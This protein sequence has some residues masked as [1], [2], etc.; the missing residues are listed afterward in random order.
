MISWGSLDWQLSLLSE[1]AWRTPEEQQ[2]DWHLVPVCVHAHVRCTVSGCISVDFKKRIGKVFCKC[3]VSTLFTLYH[4]ERLLNGQCLEH[5]SA[6]INCNL[7]GMWCQISIVNGPGRCWNAVQT[8]D[9]EAIQTE[10]LAKRHA[11][12]PEGRMHGT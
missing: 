11:T 8:N 1:R 12:S 7:L 2:Q 9:A 10:L 4:K 6:Q 3:S 5:V